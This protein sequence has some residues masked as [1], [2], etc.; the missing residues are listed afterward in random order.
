ML[1]LKGIMFRRCVLFYAMVFGCCVSALGADPQVVYQQSTDA[2]YNLD[3]NTAQRGYETLTREYPD[4]PDYWNALA[5]SIWLHILYDQ[6]KLNLDSFSGS[7]LGTK[8]SGDEVNPAEEKRLRETIDTAIAKA[9]ALLKKNPKDIRALYAKGISN[10]TMASF[11]AS[12][13]RSYRAAAGRAKAARDLHKQVLA[14]DPN[15]DDARLSIGAFNYVVGVIPFVIRVFLK[16]FGI[17]SDGKDL[18]I[19]QIETAAAKGKTASTDARMMLIVVYNREKRY[20]QALQILDSLHTRYPRNFVFH[21]GK[22]TT[23]GKM[24]KWDEAVK[25]YH[26]IL[27][28][29]ERKQDGYERLAPHK[30]YY[31]LGTS[32]MELHQ[33]DEAMQSFDKVTRI[34]ESPPDD[35]AGSHLWIGKMLD[36]SG[37]RAEALK[38]YDAVLA[39]NCDDD[40]KSEARKY[41]RN[42]FK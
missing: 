28:K 18:G 41:K 15:F 29:V 40:L 3:F 5:S 10:A 12:A 9:D 24:K 23:Y 36:S 31:S 26:E 17:S 37:R 14:M 32:Q 6:Q 21:L 20:D 39:I 2:L 7:S 19:Q 8:E 4:N 35:K 25:T 27:A 34:K 1:S 33:F 16:P 42:A 11:E 13:K 38:H 30:V 22:A